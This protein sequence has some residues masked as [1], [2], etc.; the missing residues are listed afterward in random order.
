MRASSAIFGG[1]C[2]RFLSP[3]SRFLGKRRERRHQNDARRGKLLVQ[4]QPGDA[5]WAY[6]RCP[7]VGWLPGLACPHHDRTQSNGVLRATDF[8][9]MLRRSPGDA[10]AVA[11]GE[12]EERGA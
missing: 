10:A 8:E 5:P 3:V 9:Q 4:V 11:P 12:A 7:C 2:Y 1:R 6:V